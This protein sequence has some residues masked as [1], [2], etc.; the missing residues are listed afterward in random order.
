[1]KINAIDIKPGF[2]LEHQGKLWL[3]LR[4]ELVQPGHDSPHKADIAD[5]AQM[6][7]ADKCG[8]APAPRAWQVRQFDRDSSYANAG[9]IHKPVKAHENRSGKKYI[10]DLTGGYLQPR[11]PHHTEN[12]PAACRRKQAEGHE[13]DPNRT[14]CVINADCGIEITPG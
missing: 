10:R 9:G 13:P 4:R 14:D 1:M 11:H 3:V 7:I 12:N 5:V 2:V 8:H 6:R